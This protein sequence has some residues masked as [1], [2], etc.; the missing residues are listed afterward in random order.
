MATAELELV[1]EAVLPPDQQLGPI[2]PVELGRASGLT[3][4]SAAEPEILAPLLGQLSCALALFVE[5]ESE[6]AFSLHPLTETLVYG[7]ELATTQRYRGKTNERLTR[8]M[9][10]MALAAAGLSPAGPW[11]RRP[12]VLDPMCGRGTTL[13]WALAY[14]LDAVGIEPDSSALGHHDVFLKTWAKRNRLP[15]NH[16]SHRAKNAEKRHSSLT[17]AP[18]RQAQKQGESHRVQTFKADGGDRSLPIKKGTVDLIVCDLPY[19]I[20]HESNPGALDPSDTVDLVVR[21]APSWRR[22]LRRGG[23]MALA[24]NVRRATRADLA[25]VLLEAGFHQPNRGEGP[26]MEHFVDSSITRDV[27]VVVA[28]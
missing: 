8:A 4:A 21:M 12:L 18:S 13:N 11:Q 3:F 19:G 24:W 10:N 15:H 1:A 2:N 26:S 14:G 6:A 22:W 28:P 16:Q 25:R 7:T 17:V 27:I 9:L 5:S 23:S 20:H